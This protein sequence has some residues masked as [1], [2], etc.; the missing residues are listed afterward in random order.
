MQYIRDQ[1]CKYKINLNF[2]SGKNGN[3]L[4]IGTLLLN[5]LDVGQVLCRENKGI[6]L[7]MVHLHGVKVILLSKL[8]SNKFIFGIVVRNIKI[9]MINLLL[10]FSNLVKVI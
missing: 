2:N 9:I 8:I 4:N 10:C 3:Y 6:I 1:R 7:F 5:I